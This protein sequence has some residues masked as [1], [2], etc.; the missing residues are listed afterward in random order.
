MAPDPQPAPQSSKKTI[1]RLVAVTVLLAGID[2]VMGLCRHVF[3]LSIPEWLKLIFHMGYEHN[4]PS[5]ISAA[6]AAWC[7]ILLWKIAGSDQG[8][9]AAASWYLLAGC[10]I[11]LALDEG[12]AFH[13]KLPALMNRIY[14]WLNE[15][16]WQHSSDISFV[17]PFFAGIICIAVF[18]KLAMS[19]PPLTRRLIVTAGLLFIT[20]AFVL[21]A[22]GFVFTQTHW[23]LVPIEETLEMLGLILFAYALKEYQNINARHETV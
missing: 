3:D 1:L 8:K 14:P 19:L 16:V 4:V 7:A 21:E 2:V 12:F 6:I 9:K 10:F 22:A 20:G 13:E 5:L 11:F 23:L 15:H 17:I 18:L